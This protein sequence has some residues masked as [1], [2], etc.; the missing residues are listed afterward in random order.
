MLTRLAHVVARQKWIFKCV[1]RFRRARAKQQ[2][3]N[4]L[5]PREVAAFVQSDGAQPRKKGARSVVA[6]ARHP[7]GDKCFLQD[8][9]R[10]VVMADIAA[11]EAIKRNFVPANDLI[12]RGSIPAASAHGQSFIALRVHG[13][14]SDFS[15]I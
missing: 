10:V 14:V 4:C 3:A 15:T 9:V 5:A 6:S 12:E 11:D 13:A 1:L 8:I 2:P 7:C